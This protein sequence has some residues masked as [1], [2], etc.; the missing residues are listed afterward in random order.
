MAADQNLTDLKP[1]NTREWLMHLNHRFDSLEESQAEDRETMLSILKEQ[2]EL[3]KCMDDR[4]KFLEGSAKT[5]EEAIST[6]K[7]T[8]K[9]WD[10]GSILVGLGAFITAL[11][12]LKG[13]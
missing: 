3:N 1:Q 6:L 8:Q 13:S 2:K 10:I 12:G 7:K 9:N 4:L 5:H 11:F